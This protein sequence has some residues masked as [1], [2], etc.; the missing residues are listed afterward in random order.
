MKDYIVSDLYADDFTFNQFGTVATAAK[1][2]SS[3]ASMSF[4][5]LLREGASMYVNAGFA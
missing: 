1:A 2:W 5:R 4:R 3:D